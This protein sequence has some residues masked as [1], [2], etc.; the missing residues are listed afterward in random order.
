MTIHASPRVHR[1]VVL[2]GSLAGLLAARALADHYAEVLVVD[3]DDLAAAGDEPRRGVPQGTQVHGLLLGGLAAIERLL[4]GYTDCLVARGATHGDVAAAG[5]LVVPPRPARAG[6]RRA[7]VRRREPAADR[8]RGPPSRD[9]APQRA[10]PRRHGRRGHHRDAGRRPHHRRAHRRPGT[11]LGGHGGAGRPRRRRHRPRLPHAH[12]AR[13]PRPRRRRRRSG[14]TSGS[15]TSPGCSRSGPA[16]RSSTPTSS[17][18]ARRTRTPASSCARRAAA[19]SSRSPRASGSPSR[20]TSATSAPSRA[21]SRR[22]RSAPSPRASRSA[23]VTTFRFPTS[24]WRH[25][26]R[27]ES[28]PTGLVVLGDAVCSFD[29]TFGQ[30]MSAAAMEAEV[31]QR[32]LARGRDGVERRVAAGV[33]DVARIP[34]TLATGTARRLP[35]MPP[36]PLAERVLDRYLSRL[37]RVATDDEARGDGVPPRGQPGREAAEPARAARRR[38]GRRPTVEGPRERC[39]GTGRARGPAAGPGPRSTLAR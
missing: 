10:G 37:V 23:S 32:E 5:R 30:G 2:G 16:T 17:R 24:R 15:P 20:R 29:P 6:G 31:L 22:P 27:C 35:G 28:L 34:W 21:G 1:A 3:R 39:T 12:L 26:E 36:K 18:C 14:S 19:G 25:Y 13:G 33:A 4:P 8:G 7:G 38:A 9:G 11:G